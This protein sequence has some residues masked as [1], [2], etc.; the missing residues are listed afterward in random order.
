VVKTPI[1]HYGFGGT[2]TL[3]QVTDLQATGTVSAD[4]SGSVPES[5]M[6]RLLL[7]AKKI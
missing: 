1:N 2:G 6:L 4:N 3:N 7:A 5:S